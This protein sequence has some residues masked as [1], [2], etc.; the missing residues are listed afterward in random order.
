MVGGEGTIDITD[1]TRLVSVISNML[2]VTI[3]K[4]LVVEIVLFILLLVNDVLREDRLGFKEASILILLAP[5]TFHLLLYSSGAATA[6]A[7]V[8]IVS[9]PP[10]Q[11]LLLQRQKLFGMSVQTMRPFL[12]RMLIH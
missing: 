10:F 4:L 2:V 5:D 11:L 9:I 6:A 7:A 3:V 12:E 8:V 1:G